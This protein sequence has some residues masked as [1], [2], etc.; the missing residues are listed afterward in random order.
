[1]EICYLIEAST[2]T[3]GKYDIHLIVHIL[4]I[5]EVWLL[6]ILPLYCACDIRKLPLGHDKGVVKRTNLCTKPIRLD[7]VLGVPIHN[8]EISQVGC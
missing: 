4:Q 1:M 3:I 5:F 7:S 8:F 2:Y 6:G